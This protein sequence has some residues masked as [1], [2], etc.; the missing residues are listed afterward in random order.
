MLCYWVGLDWIGLDW[1]GLDWVGLGWIG[2]DWVG[3]GWIAMEKKK[4]NEQ[5]I[6]W[7]RK[8]RHRNLRMIGLI[9]GW[10]DGWMN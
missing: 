9:N 10:M 8:V 4:R 2:L 6:N 5:E 7:K 1:I 3:L